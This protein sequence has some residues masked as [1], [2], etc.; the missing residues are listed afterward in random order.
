MPVPTR[1]PTGCTKFHASIN[2]GDRPWMSMSYLPHA[3]DI[4]AEGFDVTVEYHS[5]LP[6]YGK[7]LPVYIVA[8]IRLT[9]TPHP[10]VN[11]TNVVS[12]IIRTIHF[13]CA[14]ECVIVVHGGERGLS[15]WFASRG[16]DPSF[17]KKACIIR[18]CRGTAPQ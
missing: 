13:S 15:E 18:I 3:G 1:V 5:A 2:D 7:D 4:H 12:K 16:K 6:E 11:R 10:I 14:R 17:A 8:S 9:D